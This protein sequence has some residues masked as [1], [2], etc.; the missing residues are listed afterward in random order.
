MQADGA[1]WFITFGEQ[2]F[3]AEQRSTPGHQLGQTTMKAVEFLAVCLLALAPARPIVAAEVTQTTGS[4]SQCSPTLNGNGNTSLC[5]VL[6]PPVTPKNGAAATVLLNCE[7]DT[8]PKIFKPSEVVHFLGLYPV[9]TDIVPAVDQVGGMV[10]DHSLPWAFSHSEKEWQWGPVG[11]TAYK[12]EIGN[13]GDAPILEV[14]LDLDLTFYDAV[15]VQNQSNAI[16]TGSQILKRPWR[17]EVDK[18]DIGPL[19]SFS[20]YIYNSTEDKIVRLIVS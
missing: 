14:E 16:T 2:Q 9:S 7:R 15:P 4:G 8:F 18:I 5:Y 11:A 1:K 3:G 10:V 20:F 12:C 17:I 6:P 19:N 13:Y